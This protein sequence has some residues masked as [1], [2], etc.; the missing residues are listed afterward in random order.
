MVIAWSVTS[1]PLAPDD[2]MNRYQARNVSQSRQERNGEKK[3]GSQ[4]R[5]IDGD[6][7]NVGRVIE[8]RH[9][10]PECVEPQPGLSRV[11]PR[12]VHYTPLGA[13][14]ILCLCLCGEVL[15]IFQEEQWLREIRAVEGVAGHQVRIDC[16][17]SSQ[18]QFGGHHRG[19]RTI[20]GRRDHGS[21]IVERDT[22]YGGRVGTD[23]TGLD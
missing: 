6:E 12:L 3:D 5:H 2:P 17:A 20:G 10:I 4:S 15:T 13:R 22:R 14:E 21:A 23:P 8:A 9:L 11:A 16:T 19:H 18:S 1:V 7:V